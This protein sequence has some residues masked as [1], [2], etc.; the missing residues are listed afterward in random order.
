MTSAQPP[1]AAARGAAVL[2]S[3]I[4][5]RTGR[6]TWD[7]S[8]ALGLACAGLCTISLVFLVW[9]A[10]AFSL[11]SPDPRWQLTTV[12]VLVTVGGPIPV[13][14]TVQGFATL[15]RLRLY[16]VLG[17][18]IPRPKRRTG[19]GPW[20][21]GPWRSVVTWR[22]V[23]YHAVNLLVG[24][25]GATLVLLCQPAP[26]LAIGYTATSEQPLAALAIMP[27]VRDQH[28]APWAARTMSD[29]DERL[30][31][32]L[33]GPTHD[34]ALMEQVQT[35]ARSRAEIL[36]AP[37]AERR[38]IDRDLHAGAQQRLVS[39]AMNLGLARV[40]AQD[41]QA[42]QAIADA[43][44]EAL[45]ALTEMRQFIRGLHP[46]VLSDRGLDAALS[47]IV[48]RAVLPVRLPV[49]VPERVAPSV[50][51]VAYILVSEALTNIAKHAQATRA[52]VIVI[53]TGARLRITLTDNGRG[54]ATIG[55]EDA[56][57]HG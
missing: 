7:A 38:R 33:L 15:Q 50:E 53:R 21:I 16:Q 19:L 20:P 44:E 28:A 48:V 54:G 4:S 1:T 41:D 5:A 32:A 45:L 24:G 11:V 12:Y 23:K 37:A 3:L 34:E 25:V 36:A 47:G 35:L 10:A 27:A 57:G 55:R 22:E 13:L 6:A 8:T 51:A 17:V 2:R 31:R 14:W 46:A 49:E 9:G 56:G 26:A 42:G 30:G 39:L 18:E 52:E 29:L 40:H 43:H